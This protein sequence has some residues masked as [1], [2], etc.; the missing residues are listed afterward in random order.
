MKK[1]LEALEVE[2]GKDGE[3]RLVQQQGID[4]LDTVIIHVDQVDILI[5]WLRDAKAEFKNNGA[6]VR[7]VKIQGV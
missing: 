3:I 7:Q 5:Q 1:R 2:T 6:S 4:E